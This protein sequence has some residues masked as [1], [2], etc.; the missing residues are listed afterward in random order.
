MSELKVDILD[1]SKDL[2]QRFGYHKT[3]LTDIA[4]SVGK[5]KTA[6]YYYF[7]GKEEIFARLVEKEAQSFFTKLRNE[8]IKEQ[9]PI[10]QLEKYVDTRIMLMQKLSSRYSFLKQEFFELMPLVEENRAEAHEKEI[11]FIES[12]ISEGASQKLIAT[13]NSRFTAEM[14]VNS[15]KGLEIQMYVT[16]KILIDTKNIASFRSFILYGA[17]NKY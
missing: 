9:S 11:V 14:L 1:K 13:E 16:D 10:V 15:L 17:I 8:V 5:V 3:T 12:I 7:S 6:V 2:F 4:K